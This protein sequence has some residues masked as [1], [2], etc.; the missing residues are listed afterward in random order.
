MLGLLL[1]P[2]L[3]QQ[4]LP[5][6]HAES[7]NGGRAQLWVS[8]VSPQVHPE[9]L[10]VCC[11]VHVCVGMQYLH[12]AVL[13]SLSHQPCSWQWGEVSLWFSSAVTLSIE[14]TGC[15]FSTLLAEISASLC[16]CWSRMNRQAFRRA[17]SI[18]IGGA[19]FSFVGTLCLR[20]SC[21][22]GPQLCV[23]VMCAGRSGKRTTSTPSLQTVVQQPFSRPASET[24]Q[25][26]A[27]N[28]SVS[29]KWVWGISRPRSAFSNHS[30]H[31]LTPH[32]TS[33]DESRSVAASRFNCFIT[34]NNAAN[35]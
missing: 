3:S 17:V 4:L 28:L 11:G 16:C 8:P 1:N 13:W 6:I 19:A 21:R 27:P 30:K 29:C 22:V 33:V 10:W 14:S 18:Q 20:E 31:A 26:S 15:N 25:P 7:R 12:S 5:E 32:P 23:C 24:E 9:P 34:L 2:L 35:Y